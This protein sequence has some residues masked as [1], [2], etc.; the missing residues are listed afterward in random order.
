MDGYRQT[1][2]LF[3]SILTYAVYIY[4]RISLSFHNLDNALHVKKTSP[5]K[6]M[7]S[8]NLGVVELCLQCISCCRF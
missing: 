4:D 1:N 7:K 2:R 3:P 8:N 6:R 5:L